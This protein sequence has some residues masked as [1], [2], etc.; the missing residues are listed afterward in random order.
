MKTLYLLFIIFLSGNLFAQSVPASDPIPRVVFPR[1][2]AA[3]VTTLTPLTVDAAN[4]AKFSYGVAANGNIFATSGHLLPTPGG[5]SVP[6]SVTGTISKPAL[7]A[8]LG[9]FLIKGLPVLNTGVALYDLAVELGFTVSGGGSNPVSF[10][11]MSTSFCYLTA[12]GQCVPASDYCPADYPTRWVTYE[13]IEGYDYVACYGAGHQFIGS[14]P[15]TQ[16][17]PQS[18]P[19]S[20]T[21]LLDAIDAKSTWTPSTSA[22]PRIVKEVI[23][24]GES[25]S[26]SPS[27]ITGPASLPVSSIVTT[28]ANDPSTNSSTNPSTNSNTTT[29]TSTV[30]NNYSYQGANI[31]TTTTNNSSSV[32]NSTGAESSS[33]TSTSKPEIQDFKVCGLPD[34]PACRLDETG[35]QKD[36][37]TSY[38]KSK[39]EI[40]VVVQQSN[41]AITGASSITAPSWTFS[42]LFPTGCTPYVTGLRGV[43][44]DVC[45]FKSTIHDLMSMIWSAVTVF[46]IIGMVGRTIREA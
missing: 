21:D 36:L 3:N 14:K 12:A 4:A 42:F 32:N 1:T 45:R 26:L 5:G 31:T 9:R 10:Q 13:I 46:C 44:L 38:D 7:R 2:I 8:A 43:V 40:D 34:T 35:T 27:S 23:S 28:T 17:S 11:K 15:P 6:L 25:L 30:T 33:S 29:S 16:T 18:V 19:A 20:T 39:S 22:L 24:S 37:G 41:S